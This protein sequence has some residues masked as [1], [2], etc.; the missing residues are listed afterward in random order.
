MKKLLFSG[1]FFLFVL[2][3]V[4]SQEFNKTLMTIDNQKISKDEFVRIYKKNNN[5]DSE[6]SK[7]VDDYL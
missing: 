7:S 5:V 3:N 6:G 2:T 4:W 1:L